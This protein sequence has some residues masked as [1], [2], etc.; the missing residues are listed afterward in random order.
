VL[1]DWAKLGA[2]FLPLGAFLFRKIIAQSIGRND[3]LK[4]AQN[5]P[6]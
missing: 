6:T 2:F 5:S 3:L 1:P 4:I